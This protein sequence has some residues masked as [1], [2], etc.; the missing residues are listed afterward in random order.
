MDATKTILIDPPVECGGGKF[1]T[2]NLREFTAGEWIKA[3]THKV[4]TK[5]FVALIA[6]VSGWPEPAVHLLPVRKFNEAV[7]FLSGFLADGPET[8]E[9]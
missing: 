1:D 6:A 9:N 5:Q 8:G 7:A 4:M 3:E 2:L